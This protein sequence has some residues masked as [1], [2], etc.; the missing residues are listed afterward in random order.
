MA[1]RSTDAH[2]LS[3]EEAAQRRGEANT[4]VQICGVEMRILP[5]CVCVCVSDY[6]RGQANMI[7]G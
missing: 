7:P 3:E 4:L 1:G 2:D 5:V 6:A